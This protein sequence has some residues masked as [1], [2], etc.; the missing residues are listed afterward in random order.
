MKPALMPFV[1]AVAM[2]VAMLGAYHYWL[3]RP[4]PAI[5][6]VDAARVYR[7]EQERYL[8]AISASS[9]DAARDRAIAAAR[10]FANTFPAHLAS[11]EQDCRCLV[12]DR[13][14]IAAAPGA[15][16]DLTP[17]LRHRVRP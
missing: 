3:V 12:V 4:I 5:G 13:S 1:A 7:E 6:V 10:G 2:N 16:I 14:A 17:Q 8:Q 11:L 9:N 15:I